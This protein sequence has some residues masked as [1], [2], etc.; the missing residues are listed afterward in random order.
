MQQIAKVKGRTFSEQ[1]YIHLLVFI[2]LEEPKTTR[3]LVD[4]LAE[5][6]LVRD[7]RTIQRVVHELIN[8]GFP[9]ARKKIKGNEFEWQWADS[10][11]TLD[12]LIK[13]K[14]SAFLARAA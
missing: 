13:A 4:E 1:L 7:I 5:H 12:S 11:N 6:G 2:F 3:Q 9:I 8:S 10:T 14:A